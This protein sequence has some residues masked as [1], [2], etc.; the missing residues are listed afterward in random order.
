M[1]LELVYSSTNWSTSGVTRGQGS[2]PRAQQARNTKQ[3][4]QNILWITNTKVCV[5]KIDELAKCSLSQRTFASLISS[6]LGIGYSIALHS[7]LLSGLV[8]PPQKKCGCTGAESPSY[9]SVIDTTAPQSVLLCPFSCYRHLKLSSF[10][11]CKS[12]A[13]ATTAADVTIMSFHWIAQINLVFTALC[14]A[15]AVL[16]MGLCLSLSVTSRSSTITAKCRI[17]QTTPH[18]SPGTLVFWCQR[19]PRNST[20]VTPYEDAECRWGGSKSATFD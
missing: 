12:L 11:S 9:A 14:Y 8:A 13:F 2:C 4:Q 16:A 18:D 1:Q 6:L 17:T 19:S 20:G 15:S 10:T 7:I 5:I 3:H